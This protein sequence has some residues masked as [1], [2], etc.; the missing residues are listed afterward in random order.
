MSRLTVSYKKSCLDATLEGRF[1]LSEKKVISVAK[2]WCIVCIESC[3]RLPVLC[4]SGKIGGIRQF[5]RSFLR[6]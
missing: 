6:N 2:S 5:V 4:N 1:A 3:L